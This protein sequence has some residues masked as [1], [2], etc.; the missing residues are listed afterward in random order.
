ME[1]LIVELFFIVYCHLGGTQNDRQYFARN[2]FVPSL[3]L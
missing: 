3:L 2:F 1:I